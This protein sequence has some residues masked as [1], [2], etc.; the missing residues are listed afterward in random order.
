MERMIR[1]VL[2]EKIL[3]VIDELPEELLSEIVDFIGYLKTKKTDKKYED[4]TLAS[5]EI[6]SK[7]W[8]KQE[9]EEAWIHL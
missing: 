8:L 5:E 6:L 9:E 7:D 2:K 1:M 3:E 4:I